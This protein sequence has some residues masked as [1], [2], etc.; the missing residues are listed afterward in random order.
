M[1]LTLLLRAFL[2]ALVTAILAIAAESIFVFAM[3]LSGHHVL[4]TSFW[5]L[6]L[7]AVLMAF[8]PVWP[9]PSRISSTPIGLG[10]RVLLLIEFTIFVAAAIFAS[11]KFMAYQHVVVPVEIWFAAYAYGLV[12][13]VMLFANFS[14]LRREISASN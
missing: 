4:F 7:F 3:R 8:M 12:L 14:R 9:S 1:P 2:L 10:G 11:A 6:V 13:V 5:A